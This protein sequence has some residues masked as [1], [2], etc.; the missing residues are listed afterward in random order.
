VLSAD[1]D[2]TDKISDL[3]SECRALGIEVCPPDINRCVF[4]F[5][6]DDDHTVRY[7]LGAVKGVGRNAIELITDQRESGGP[8]SSLGDFCNRVDLRKVNRRAVEVLVRCGAMD[9][10]DENRNR[11]ALVA[12]L[13]SA[14]QAAEQAQRDRET[15][16]SDMFGSPVEEQIELPSLSG[17]ESVRPWSELQVLQAERDTLGLYLTGHPVS[18]QAQD[19]ACFTSCTI[20]R[21]SKLIALDDSQGRRRRGKPMTLAGMVQAV[22]RRNNGGGFVSIEDGTGRLEVSMFDESW[23]LYADL[24]TKDEIIVIEGDVSPDDFSG[25]FRMRAQKVMS[26]R[27]A[28]NRFAS[29]VSIALRG[30]DPKLV[31]DLLATFAPYRRGGHQVFIDYSNGRARAQLELGEDFKIKACDEL[32]AALAELE[33]VQGARLVY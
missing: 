10:L 1:M 27:D 12:Q 20:D 16:Q 24:L 31:D 17:E 33:H 5:R 7:G 13:P 3:I 4:A 30:P 28:K 19:L 26:L 32:V 18:L 14:L 2:N 11:A 6:A 22:R 9:S 29:G 25:G 23:S 8:Y 15:G 21:V